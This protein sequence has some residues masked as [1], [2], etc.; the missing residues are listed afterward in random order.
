MFAY[1][2]FIDLQQALDTVNRDILLQKLGHYG[3]R[4]LPNKWFQSF[5]SGRPQYTGLKDKRSYKL[6]ITHGVLQG[7]VLD[8]PLFILCINDVNKAIIHGYV[9]HFSDDANLLYSK[10]SFKTKKQ[11]SKQKE[12]CKPL[13][14]TPQTKSQ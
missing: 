1:G 8:S 9:H 6:P 10:K 12:T 5:L 13:S 11:K 4:G 14:E 7:S 2:I 3:I